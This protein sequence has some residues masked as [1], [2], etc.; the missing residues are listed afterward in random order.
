M[1]VLGCIHCGGV[2]PGAQNPSHSLKN[3]DAH[4]NS[5]PVGIPGSSLANMSRDIRGCYKALRV[6]SF[7]TV[8]VVSHARDPILTLT[9]LD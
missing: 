4:G 6:Q 9:F 5:P 3:V 8:C 1:D 2:S 7:S